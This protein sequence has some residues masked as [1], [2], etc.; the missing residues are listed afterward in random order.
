MSDPQGLSLQRSKLSNISK[1]GSEL[2][3]ALSHEGRLTI[4][5]LLCEKER[6]V[7]ELETILELRQPAVSQQLARL[8]HDNLV[9]TR[10]EGK[11][12]YYSLASEQ[13]REVVSTL[14]RLYGEG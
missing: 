14:T 8:R 11:L 1:A 12:I 5:A 13:A 4:L 9:A 7:T 2:L 3:K 6:S 10:R